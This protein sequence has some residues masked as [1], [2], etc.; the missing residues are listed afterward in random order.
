[1]TRYRNGAHIK[2]QIKLFSKFEYP[3][4]H[5]D[6]MPNWIARQLY[7]CVC[8]YPFFF[9]ISWICDY[10]NPKLML[11]RIKKKQQT[12]GF[13]SFAINSSIFI[14]MNDSEICILFLF[15]FCISISDEKTIFISS[16]R[17]TWYSLIKRE[18]FILN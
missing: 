9:W 15:F 17:I 5:I 11:I 4:L 10:Q 13:I 1:M 2:W 14:K 16:N 3:K 8:M 12:N 6:K 18:L 7:I